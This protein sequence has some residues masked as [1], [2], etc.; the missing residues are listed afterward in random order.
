MAAV[1]WLY[2]LVKVLCSLLSYWEIR[3]FYIKA[4]NIPSVSGAAGRG[5][6]GGGAVRCRAVPCRH[7]SACR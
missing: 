1:F 7:R 5:L 2:R 3:T 6:A 4:L